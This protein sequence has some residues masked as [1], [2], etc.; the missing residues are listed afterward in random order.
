M[1]PA[2]ARSTIV[3]AFRWGHRRSR[4]PPAH[5]DSLAV[6]NALRR[7]RVVDLLSGARPRSRRE[8]LRAPVAPGRARGHALLPGD[9]A[10]APA[11]RGGA[12]PAPELRLGR[13]RA[14]ERP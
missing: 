13:D 7:A 8:R 4:P 1:V 10:A 14:R 5:G 2:S 11:R 12:A 3:R 6:P 9:P